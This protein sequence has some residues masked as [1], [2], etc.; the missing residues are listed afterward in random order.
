MKLPKQRVEGNEMRGNGKSQAMLTHE[1]AD[2]R[3][4]K[5]GD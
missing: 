4:I 2:L 3:R 1:D 5:H